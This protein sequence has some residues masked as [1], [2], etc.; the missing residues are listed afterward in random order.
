MAQPLVL[1]DTERDELRGLLEYSIRGLGAEIQ[2]AQARKAA[3]NACGIMLRAL[4]TGERLLGRLN[5]DATAA[6][7]RA[8]IHVAK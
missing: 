5:G 2:A 3:P 4:Q 1:T 8:G 7:T 6:R